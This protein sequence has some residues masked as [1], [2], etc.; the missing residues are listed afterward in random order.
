MIETTRRGCLQKRFWRIQKQLLD[1]NW[2]IISAVLRTAAV[3]R[4]INSL[5][6][7]L[8]L[9]VRLPTTWDEPDRNG[10]DLRPW[11]ECHDRHEIPSTRRSSRKQIFDC[12]NCRQLLYRYADRLDET[13][14]G[15]EWESWFL[16]FLVGGGLARS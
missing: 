4:F 8:A 12:E 13:K 1:H 5:A 6:G 11:S 15:E 2:T 14:R 16:V 7:K 3:A 10:T 9:S